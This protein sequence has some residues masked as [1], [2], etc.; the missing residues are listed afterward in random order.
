VITKG[1]VGELRHRSAILMGVT[2]PV[3]QDQSRI[4]IALGGLEGVLDVGALEREISVA[5]HQHLD[6][7]LRNSRKVGGLFRASAAREPTLLKT[8]SSHDE[9]GDLGGET[10][11]RSATADL[12][13]V[14]VRT[15]AKQLLTAVAAPAEERHE[16]CRRPI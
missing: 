9:V 13:V 11:N 5:E 10:Q 6:L 14:R 4:E 7:S 3:S 12:D 16:A 2:L 1:V 15:Q 8:N